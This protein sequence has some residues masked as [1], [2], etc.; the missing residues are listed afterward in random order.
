LVS[1]KDTTSIGKKNSLDRIDVFKFRNYNDINFE[2][3]I[4]KAGTDNTNYGLD[5]VSN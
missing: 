4:F 2:D 1:G 5:T 3:I